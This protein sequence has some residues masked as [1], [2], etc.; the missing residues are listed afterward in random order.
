ML[1]TRPHGNFGAVFGGTAPYLNQLFLGLDLGW[2]FGVY[3]MFLAALTGVA[4][5]YMKETK[6]IRLEDV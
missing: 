1:G 4:C 3:I 5:F 2:V 6:G